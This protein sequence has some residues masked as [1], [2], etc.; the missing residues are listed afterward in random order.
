MKQYVIDE[1]R[2]QDQEKI[3]TYLDEHFGPA[4]LGDLYW[5]PLDRD[6]YDPK[7]ASHTDCHPLFFAVQ[8]QPAALAAELLVRTKNRVRADCIQY[9]TDDQFRWLIRLVDAIFEHLGVMA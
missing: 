9:A 8:L 1:L 3:K 5:I 6:L 2:P 4:E 7:Q